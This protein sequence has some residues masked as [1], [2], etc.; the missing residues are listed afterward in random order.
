MRKSIFI[1]L[2]A[3]CFLFAF[4]LYFL[5]IGYKFTGLLSFVLGAY[6]LFLALTCASSARSIKIIRRVVTALAIAGVTLVFLLSS[7][8]ISDM[9][10]DAH[11]K[12]DYAIVLGAGL[13][14]DTPS[15]TL[16]ERLSKTAEYLDLFPDCIAIVSGG[17]G[18]GETI[19]EAEAMARYLISHGIDKDRIIKEDK[20]KNTY[21]NF[22]FS[23]EKIEDRADGYFTLAVISSDYHICRARKIARSFGVSPVM[24]SADTS[25]PVLKLNY[26]LREAFA[27]VKTKLTI[28][29]S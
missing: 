10:G 18:P 20:A 24:V 25:L 8:V 27:L 3:I 21:E 2:S 7:I 14:G 19:T 1:S 29:G 6:F 9:N 5:L 4:V 16:A 15:L 23:L 11:Q 12:A 26:I 28:G 13:D 17:M 22:L